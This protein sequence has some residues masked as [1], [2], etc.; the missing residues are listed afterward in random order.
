[1]MRRLGL[2]V[3]V[4]WAGN[5]A[6]SSLL[7]P[8]EVDSLR[9]ARVGDR[10]TLGAVPTGP[11]RF[12]A[13]T[14]ERIDVYAPDAKIYEMRLD[15]PH[16]IPRSTDLQFISKSGLRAGFSLS[17]DGERLSG[18]VY[19]EDG[20]AFRLGGRAAPVGF[21]LELGQ[22]LDRNEDGTPAAFNLGD[23]NDALEG[24]ALPPDA[25]SAAQLKAATTAT[26]QAVVAVETNNELLVRKFADNTTTATT[27]IAGLFTNMNAI[28]ERDLDVTLVQGTTFLWPSAMPDP[29]ASVQ[30][31]ST[32]T[33]L[34]EFGEYW[35]THHAVD[36]SAAFVLMLSGKINSGGSSGIAWLLT[37][38]N[39]CTATGQQFGGQTFGHFALNQVFAS[40]TNPAGDT[41]VTAHELGHNFGANH[42]HCTDNTTGNQ[43]VGTNTID[44]C[45][46]GESGSGCY[47]GTATCPAAHT[48]NGVANVKGTLMSYCHIT[49]AGCGV[50]NVFADIHR[51][52][53][54]ARIASNF[55]SCITATTAVNQAPSVAAG[56]SV[57][58]TEDT[59]SNVTDIT[60]TDNDSN[61]LSET[62]TLT[63]ATGALSGTTGGGVTVGGTPTALT[64][65]GSIANLNMFIGMGNLKYTTAS[66]A[67]GSVTLNIS[68]NDNGNSGTGGAK[69][70]NGSTSLV[71]TAV[72]DAP[73]ITAP[74]SIAVTEDV[75][76]A[77]TGISFTDVDSGTNPVVVTLAPATGTINAPACA[78]VTTGGT[79]SSRTLTGTVA[80][81]NACL[82]AASVTFTTA[83]NATSNVTLALTID[84]GG[85]TG[86]GGA[87]NANTSV[88]LTVTAVNDAPTI[89]AP[90]TLV[91]G[92][93]GATAV[94]GLS[95]ADIDA[96][97]ASVT[98]TLATTQGTFVAVTG[99]GVTV[100][101]S[102]TASL[103][104]TGTVA[105]IDAF[106][107]T[108]S[109]VSFVA[110]LP[111]TND[112]ATL[113]STVND[114]GNTGTGGA[115]SA[116]AVTTLDAGAIFLDG[117][118]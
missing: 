110:A 93:P 71:I 11:K 97:A 65:A 86:T 115:K 41:Y 63:V 61:G 9:G 77:L 42:S 2:A 8:S 15:G 44:Q 38:G 32:L 18:T 57:S 98:L 117:F 94:N 84:D 96:G 75:A 14:L 80:N 64:L 7:T 46:N 13:I 100:G 114:N 20:T 67:N 25:L 53:L 105:N 99:G 22:P 55:P 70:G 4:L 62:A 87:K 103:T 33:E 27:F 111:L 72:N 34:N 73:S 109:Q 5:A 74:G 54:A 92:A 39:Y 104:L 88:P 31:V 102:A 30:G 82:A 47:A 16:E 59:L 3:A 81:I 60:F 1:M 68:I 112:T 69:T 51:T 113:T 37:S 45:Y 89:A 36:V 78:N 76:T 43:P 107:A 90:S 10:V 79:A 91:V 6:A 118:E 24:P 19:A 50:S 95:I 116:N 21:E 58:V 17:A 28:Y 48:V 66:N 29:Y 106:L 83:L 23:P 40:G 108:P 49:P 35:R 85:N 101:G 56:P 12:A 52:V 26:R